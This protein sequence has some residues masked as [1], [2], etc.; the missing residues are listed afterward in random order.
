MAPAFLVAQSCRYVDLDG[1]L[2]QRLDRQVP[3][4]FACSVMHPPAQALWG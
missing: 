4:R 2:L 1:P 3:I